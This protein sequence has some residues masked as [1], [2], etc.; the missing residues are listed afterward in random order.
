MHTIQIPRDFKE[1]LK[2]LIANDARFLV[3]GGY[4]VNA[5]GHIRNTVDLDIWIAADAENRSRV[6]QAI[7]S[8]A[9]PNAGVEMFDRPDAMVRMGVPPLRIEVL[10]KIAG[11]EFDD[12]SRRVILADEDIQIPMISLDDLKKNKKAAGRP[13]DLLDVDGLS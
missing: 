3:I 13:K 7:R 1:F 12:W 5:F 11:V 6:V 2:L 8:F 9:F 4:A 10:Q